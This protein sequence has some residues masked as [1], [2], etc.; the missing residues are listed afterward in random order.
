MRF[1]GLCM[2]VK[3]VKNLQENRERL[4]MTWQSATGLLCFCLYKFN[5]CKYVVYIPAGCLCRVVVSSLPGRSK[6]FVCSCLSPLQSTAV[7]LHS[8]KTTQ[9]NSFKKSASCVLIFGSL[10]IPKIR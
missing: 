2:S 1:Q 8:S 7:A 6:A 9:H 10:D 5:L 4:T 3:N